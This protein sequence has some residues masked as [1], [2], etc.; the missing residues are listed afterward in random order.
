M[1]QLTTAG[2]NAALAGLSIAYVSAHTAAPGDSGA[3]EVSG[4]SYARVAAT[5]GTPANG[6]RSATN[7]PVLN[8]PASNTITHIGYW[9]AASG[10]AL[11][12]WDDLSAPVAFSNAGTFTVN[13][14]NINF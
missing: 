2:K 9:T 14:G 7:A 1:G 3:S 12:A 8:I 5:F 11:L 10:G 13:S 4:G 6:I